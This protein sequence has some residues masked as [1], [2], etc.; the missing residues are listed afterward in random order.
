MK[1]AHNQERG[2][3]YGQKSMSKEGAKIKLPPLPSGVLNGA[4]GQL[5]NSF[6]KSIVLNKKPHVDISEAL[7]MTM[8]GVIA[9]QSALKDGEWMKVPQYDL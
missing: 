3:V 4:N 8:S 2:R 7:N 9:H 6:I 5:T 1:N